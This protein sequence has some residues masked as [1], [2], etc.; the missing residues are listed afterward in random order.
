MSVAACADAQIKTGPYC[1]LRFSLCETIM[2]KKSNTTEI[3]ILRRDAREHLEQGA[4]TAD[5]LA[6]MR[7]GIEQD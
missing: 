3:K 1:K 7:S 6:S 4:V 5:E 2:S